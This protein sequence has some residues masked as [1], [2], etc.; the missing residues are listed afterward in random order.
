M[1]ICRRKKLVMNHGFQIDVGRGTR[2]DC[3]TSSWSVYV[4]CKIERGLTKALFCLLM[5]VARGPEALL[6]LCVCPFS[7]CLSAREILVLASRAAADTLSSS[8][9]R[10][11]FAGKSL[12]L[13]KR[14]QLWS[15]F[16]GQEIK[17]TSAHPPSPPS[18]R[19]SPSS[20]SPT[21]PPG[22]PATHTH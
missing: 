15:N 20:P 11:P 7:A 19:P 1:I 17:C 6:T 10:V 16:A 22:P 5:S 14:R 18:N 12:N 4:S 8:C 21:P 2:L 3:G 9:N 13:A